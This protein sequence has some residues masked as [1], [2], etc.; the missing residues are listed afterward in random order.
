[1]PL[2]PT[3]ESYSFAWLPR[4]PVRSLAHGNGTEVLGC[5]VPSARLWP[6]TGTRPRRGGT[7]AIS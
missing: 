5:P 3:G 6:L 4:P 7:K 2:T 1:M